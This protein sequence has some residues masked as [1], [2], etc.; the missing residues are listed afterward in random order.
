LMG[1]TIGLTKAQKLMVA[2]YKASKTFNRII[3]RIYLTPM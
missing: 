3:L 1:H 2:N